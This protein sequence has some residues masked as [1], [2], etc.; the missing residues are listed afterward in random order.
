ML[1]NELQLKADRIDWRE[2]DR[3]TIAYLECALWSSNDESTPS[4]G[5]PIDDNYSIDDCTQSFLRSAAEDCLA[6]QRDNEALLARAG[7]EGR[8]GHDFWLTRNGH[9]A[10]F[11][12]RGYEDDV[13]KGL[14]DAAHVYGT[15]DLYITDA[16]EVD[17]M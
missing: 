16:G 10:G 6:F 4:G 17:C 8:N 14:T 9:G 13:D 11:W 15:V 1:K 7:D 12:D 2:L 3:F 5:N